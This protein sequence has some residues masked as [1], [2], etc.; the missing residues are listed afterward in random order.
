MKKTIFPLITVYIVSHN[1]GRYLSE[2][3]ES[4]FRQSF[5]NWE[6]IIINDGSSDNT[7]EIIGLYKDH[8]KVEVYDTE[9]I[10]L[11]A[12][13]NLAIKKSKGKYIIRLDADDIFEENILLVLSTYMLNHEDA[14]LVFPDYY[15]IDDNGIVFSQEKNQAPHSE[16]HL[17]DSPPNGACS[18]I[19]KDVLIE[20]GGYRED[21]GAQDGLDIWL[22]MKDK[23]MTGKVSLPLFFYRRHGK[24]LTEQ[25]LKI[26][27]ARRQIKK[28]TIQSSVKEIQPVL[29][30]IPCRKNYDFVP[31]LWAAEIGG[32][33]LLEM[34]IESCLS[35][36][37]ISK[38][39]V[40]CDNLG[41]KKI[42][43][44]FNSDKVIFCERE[45]R[46]TLRSSNIVNTLKKIINQFDPNY[47]G[48][49]VLRYVQSPFVTTETIDEAISTILVSDSESSCAVKELTNR[50][51]KKTSFGLT[52]LSSD[53]DTLISTDEI[54]MDSSV[55]VAFKNSNI[56]KG[57]LKGAR[58]AGFVV[59]SA[60][61][62]FIS[63]KHDL[64]IA[65]EIFNLQEK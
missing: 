2:A 25:P 23:Y 28:T 59:S 36:T 55:S 26:F 45:E 24:N 60:E 64:M 65:Q 21:L 43:D 19:K 54:Y 18:L 47:N 58:I 30:I 1:Y 3:V 6:L 52:P 56:K 20:L 48:L 8:P 44:Q 35:S 39:I 11:P 4:V 46:D 32:K 34:D 42:V 22:K 50:I 10:G 57:T 7:D 62:F 29:A 40:A 13:N 38:V 15:L 63:S 53:P 9:G 16:D 49:S 14:A 61:S 12:V 31:D 17:M 37:L 51:Y 33:S 27:N 5:D 41:A